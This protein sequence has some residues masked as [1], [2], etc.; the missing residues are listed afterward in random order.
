MLR[1]PPASTAA[2]LVPRAD[3]RH[4]WCTRYGDDQGEDLLESF[5]VIVWVAMPTKVAAPRYLTWWH[6]S[7][8]AEVEPGVPWR[9]N[10]GDG[11]THG[12]G[13]A[14]PVAVGGR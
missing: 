7:E 9:P 14:R 5:Y 13:F 4:Q 3:L 10:G 12:H 1:D 6:R 11:Y 2:I 8:M